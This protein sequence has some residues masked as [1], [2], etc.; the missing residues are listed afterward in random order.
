VVAQNL[1]RAL[2]EARA[3]RPYTIP[4]MRVG[5]LGLISGATLVLFGVGGLRQIFSVWVRPIEADFGADRA[6]VAGIAALSYLMFGLGQPFL[7][8]LVDLGGP[9][10]VVPGAVLAAGLGALLAPLTAALWQFGL[11]FVLLT[12]VGY[13]GAA[14]ATIAAAVMQRFE[15]RRGLIFGLCSAGAPLGQLIL[16]PVA[17]VSIDGFGWRPTMAGFGVALLLVVLPAAWMLLARTPA[18]KRASGPGLL[19]TLRLAFRRRAF[20]LLFGSYFLCG[21]TTLGVVHT[22]LVPYAVDVGVSAVA[23]ARVLGLVGL[24][25][26]IG[27]IVAGQAADRWG[28]RLPLV[29]AFTVRALS[30]LWLATATDERA[31]VLFA[32]VFGLT[33]MATIPLVAAASAE[34]F[35]PRMIGALMGILVV[36]HQLGSA[37]GSY[38]AGVGYELLGSYPTVMLASAGLS[39]CAALLSLNLEARNEEQGMRNEGPACCCGPRTVSGSSR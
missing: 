33:D 15:R 16:A 32:L 3:V 24:F 18:P 34:I 5:G 8:R 1:A 6:T 14:N 37:T 25:D 30:L 17:A 36:A 31:L 12:S 29:V 10:L 2:I 19:T 35:G 9:R 28:G 7:G 26:V 21:L 11:V 22:H 20:V 38:L 4:S 39:L 13:A 23:G 27:L